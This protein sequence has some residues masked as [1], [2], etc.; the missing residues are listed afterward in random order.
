MTISRPSFGSYTRPG[1][2]TYK[3]PP[4]HYDSDSRDKLKTSQNSYENWNSL[5]CSNK[6][7]L[8]PI[9]L[10]LFIWGPTDYMVLDREPTIHN[11]SKRVECFFGPTREDILSGHLLSPVFQSLYTLQLQISYVTSEGRQSS[12][13]LTCGY[14]KASVSCSVLESLVDSF[15]RASSLYLWS[16]G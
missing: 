9:A 4:H 3:R 15:Q 12:L 6:P 11:V 10:S 5:E 7:H 14:S 2:Q 13:S 1:P 16:Y 8:S